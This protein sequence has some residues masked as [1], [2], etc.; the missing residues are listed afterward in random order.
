V[1]AEDVHDPV[2]AQGARRQA[3]RRALGDRRAVSPGANFPPSASY[4][5]SEGYSLP[6]PLATPFGNAEGL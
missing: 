1:D 6:M 3:L 2:V 5:S 4:P